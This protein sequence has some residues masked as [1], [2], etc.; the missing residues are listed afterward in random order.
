MVF[1]RRPDGTVVGRQNTSHIGDTPMKLELPEEVR[2]SLERAV[3]LRW[4][5]ARDDADRV[6]AIADERSDLLGKL[7][8]LFGPVI[9]QLVEA[10]I[11]RVYVGEDMA[12]GEAY[13][14]IN[15]VG[16]DDE[17]GID[18]DCEPV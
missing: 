12:P 10:E 2:E 4:A 11:L 17:F 7:T 8:I 6:S 9:R 3:F 18:L 16:I 1:R 5:D 15:G 13:L 14:P